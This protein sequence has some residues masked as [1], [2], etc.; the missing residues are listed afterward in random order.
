VGDKEKA[1]KKAK[2]ESKKADSDAAD[3]KNKADQ[4]KKDKPPDGDPALNKDAADKANAAKAAKDKHNK[5]KNDT[6]AA[7]NKADAAKAKKKDADNKKKVADQKA[8]DAKKKKDDDEAAR[9]KKEKDDEEARRNPPPRGSDGSALLAA[10]ALSGNPALYPQTSQGPRGPD[11]SPGADGPGSTYPGGPGSTYPGGP[12]VAPPEVAP[13]EDPYT[14]NND[15]DSNLTEEEKEEKR[16]K[17]REEERLKDAPFGRDANGVP[18]PSQEAAAA[19]APYGFDPITGKPYTSAEE[20]AAGPFGLDPVTGKPYASAA[21]AAAGAARLAALA[22]PPPTL[23]PL[24]PG[25]SARFLKME[26]YDGPMVAGVIHITRGAVGGGPPVTALI[27]VVNK[28]GIPSA[29]EIKAATEEAAIEAVRAAL[30]DYQPPPRTADV[31]VPDVP[32]FAPLEECPEDLKEG[33]ISDYRPYGDDGKFFIAY[34]RIKDGRCV[35]A[36]SSTEE[37][38]GNILK[39]FGAGGGNTNPWLSRLLA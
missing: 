13:P 17:E 1:Q 35:R 16:R 23:G 12:E 11:G 14:A 37:R 31:D 6:K 10:A 3:A 29:I 5:T 15:L 28:D 27:I 26:E 25:V 2:D 20:A 7:K 8:R 9:K 32:V 36:I 39:S 4:A 21:A 30:K 18:Y 24:P 38:L 22:S 19:G 34:K 33:R